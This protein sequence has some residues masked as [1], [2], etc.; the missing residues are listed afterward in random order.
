MV[1]DTQISCMKEQNFDEPEKFIPERWFDMPTMHH[2]FVSLPFSHGPIAGFGKRL[3]EIE[4]WSCAA[5]VNIN[6]SFASKNIFFL[7]SMK[8]NKFFWIYIFR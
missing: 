4:L 3:A 7:N 6:P 1:V 5:K 8:L 2:P